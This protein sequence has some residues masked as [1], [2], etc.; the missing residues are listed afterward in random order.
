MQPRASKDAQT[1]PAHDFMGPKWRYGRPV[2]TSTT[3][4]GCQLV[5]TSCEARSMYGP[6]G[7]MLKFGMISGSA[8]VASIRV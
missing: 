1:S 2:F 6:S 4:L 7:N 8:K 3:G 5:G